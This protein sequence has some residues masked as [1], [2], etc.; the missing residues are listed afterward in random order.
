MGNASSVGQMKGAWER[1]DAGDIVSARK[2]ALAVMK[3]PE[4]TPK[5]RQDAG[6]LLTRTKLPRE[7]YLIGLGAFLTLLALWF[8]AVHRGSFTTY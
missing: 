6:D 3:S 4:A 1:Y 2:L 5:D 8:L 7:V